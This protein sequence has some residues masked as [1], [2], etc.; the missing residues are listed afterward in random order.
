MRATRR[1]GAVGLYRS[2]LRGALVASLPAVVAFILAYV[3]NWTGTWLGWGVFRSFLWECA[4]VRPRFS[5]NI[6][7]Q[8]QG[9]RDGCGAREIRARVGT[10]HALSHFGAIA[11]EQRKRVAAVHVNDFSLR[12]EPR[13]LVE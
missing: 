10:D 4:I 11:H 7:A 6:D 3:V 13:R 5:A 1:R 8:E 9:Q 12:R 2:L